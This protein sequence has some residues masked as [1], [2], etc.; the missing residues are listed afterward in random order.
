MVAGYFI[1]HT[2]YYYELRAINKPT[3]PAIQQTPAER[4][5]ERK[6]ERERERERE[7]K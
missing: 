5:K 4:K 2:L 1:D 6:K 7:K 3:A